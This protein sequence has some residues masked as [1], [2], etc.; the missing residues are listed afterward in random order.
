VPALAKNPA[1]YSRRSYTHL[2]AKRLELTLNTL[3]SLEDGQTH[4]EVLNFGGHLNNSVNVAA[5][6]DVPN[7]AQ[8]YNV[9]LVVIMWDSGG[10]G[11]EPYF[12]APLN[13]DG[14][15]GRFADTE[16]LLQSGLEKFKTGMPREFFDLCKK[17]NILDVSASGQ[18][19]INN[20][21]KL[22]SDFDL[23]KGL[24][25]MVGNPIYLLGQKLA[26]MKRDGE[27]PCELAVCY[28]PWPAME[29]FPLRPL[30]TFP[31]KKDR[32]FWK[33]LCEDKKI[34]FVDMTDVWQT[35]RLT[36]FPCSDMVGNDHFSADGHLLLGTLL[37]YEFIR[38][39]IIPFKTPVSP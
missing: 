2:F 34:N 1:D 32:A 36:Y 16:F 4:Y 22:L 25:E 37:A 35:C 17:K 30:E 24:I 3:S 13:K 33:E 8:K 31:Y 21:P 9:D 23:R 28:F 29:T 6:Y 27:K 5:Y 19:S 39:G 11:L 26:G 18:F 14:V 20:Y 10:A 7:I 12:D 15:P 38:D